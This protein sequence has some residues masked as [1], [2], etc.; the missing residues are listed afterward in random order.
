MVQ[1]LAALKKVPLLARPYT[2]VVLADLV[3]RD[4]D[5]R[6]VAA[7]RLKALPSRLKS[8]SEIRRTVRRADKGVTV[9]NRSTPLRV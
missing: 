1:R 4:H 2:V 5:K 8:V 6:I 3:T 7:L 9:G